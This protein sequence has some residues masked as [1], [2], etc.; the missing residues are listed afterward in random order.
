[1]PRAIPLD[2]SAGSNLLSG[3]VRHESN[4]IANSHYSEYV[5]ALKANNMGDYLEPPVAPP[6]TNLQQFDN[7][8]LNGMTQ[9][10]ADISRLFLVEP[11]AVN[12]SATGVFLG[13]IN[14]YPEQPCPN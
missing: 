14:F 10:Q 9:Y 4:S 13:N 8:T 7:D 1:M 12:E 2:I 3:A 11:Y 5:E 6:G